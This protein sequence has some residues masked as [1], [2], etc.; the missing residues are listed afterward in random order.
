MIFVLVSSFHIEPSL[1]TPICFVLLGPCL[2]TIEQGSFRLLLSHCRQQQQQQQQGQQQQ[3]QGHHN[4]QR[5]SPSNKQL[6]QFLSA[7][8]GWGLIL[9]SAAFSFFFFIST[10]GL[11]SLQVSGDD[12]SRNISGPVDFG[13]AN[14]TRMDLLTAATFFDQER[15]YTVS[16]KSY[17]SR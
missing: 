13:N 2:A 1:V 8:G 5:G 16:P 6:R 7:K 9:A 12:S 3:Q 15:C 14:E 17:W 11:K 10:S 4:R